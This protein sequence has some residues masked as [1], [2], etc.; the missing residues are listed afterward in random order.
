MEQPEGFEVSRYEYYVYKLK[1]AL[2]GLKKMPRAWYSRIDKYFQDHGLVKILFEPNLYIIQSGQE[3]MV[4]ILNVDDLIY[5][6]R[7]IKLFQRFKSPMIVDFEM[8]Y[9]SELHYFWVLEFG[10]GMMVFSCHRLTI[11]GIL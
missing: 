1:K 2:Y 3:I 5:I 9:L 6:G 8:K 11:I 7:N 4:V 10:R